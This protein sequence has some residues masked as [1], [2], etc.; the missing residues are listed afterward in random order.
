LWCGVWGNIQDQGFWR[1]INEKTVDKV[2]VAGGG[3]VVI[4]GGGGVVIV[5]GGVVIVGGG[6]VIVGGGS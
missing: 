2:F 6:V 1:H 3:G 4:V 5:G